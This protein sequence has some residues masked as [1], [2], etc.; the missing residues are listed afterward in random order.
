MGDILEEMTDQ[1]PDR[2]LWM[3][4]LLAANMA[5]LALQ[6]RIAVKTIS[7]LPFFKVA[8]VG[9]ILL[10]IVKFKWLYSP[11]II[12]VGKDRVILILK[13]QL[14]KRILIII[15]L[16]P[17]TSW[18]A[19]A[20]YYYNDI[21]LNKT[22][23]SEMAAYKA[24]KVREMKTTS[25]EKD[26]TESEGFRCNKK[27]SRDY[28]KAELFTETM[29]SYPTWFISYFDKNGLLE[30]TI[31]SSE[32]ASTNTQYSYDAQGR[33]YRIFSLTSFPD[34]EAHD[35]TE[36]HIYEYGAAGI[37]VKMLMIKNKVDTMEIL[38]KADEN[39]NVG[40]EKNARTAEDYYYYY[41][42]KKR[43]TEIAHS[44]NARN[45]MTTDFVFEY[46]DANQVTRME[47][48]EKEGAYYFTWRYT[49]ENGLRATERCYSKEGAIQGSVEY[50]YK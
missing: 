22:L 29:D 30:S 14:M 7:L 2:F 42:S 33:L 8:Q 13:K 23:L 35:V 15:V 44:Y 18:T 41:D 32:A 9:L 20:Q 11:G 38:F 10:K 21:V 5:I 17:L 37:P 34:D 28:T 40:I 45:K 24:G 19:S 6:L 36:D 1:V 31:D 12:N 49:Y 47:A 27:F 46:N 3:Y 39:G 50:A 25:L 26:G 16:C 4:I 43:V 48:A